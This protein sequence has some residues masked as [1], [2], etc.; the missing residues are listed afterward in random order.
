[1]IPHDLVAWKPQ[2]RL[3]SGLSRRSRAALAL[4]ALLTVQLGLAWMLALALLS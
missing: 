4:V 3:S 1:M 2:P